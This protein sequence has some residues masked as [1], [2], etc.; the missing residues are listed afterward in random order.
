MLELNLFMATSLTVRYNI[1]M[2]VLILS[3]LQ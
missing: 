3:D 2:Y 1:H